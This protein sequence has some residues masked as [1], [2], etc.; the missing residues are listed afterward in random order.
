M[1]MTITISICLKSVIYCDQ[2]TAPSKAIAVAQG[3][4]C[5]DKQNE[6][7]EYSLKDQQ[8]SAAIFPVFLASESLADLTSDHLVHRQTAAKCSAP[9]SMTLH[10][11][12]GVRLCTSM[13]L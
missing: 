10:K 5:T 11:C 6:G 13:V 3:T 7:S 4:R 2:V 1:R 8:A 9:V 12:D